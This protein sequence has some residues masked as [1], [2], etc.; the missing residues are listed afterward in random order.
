MLQKTYTEDFITGRRSKNVGQR[1]RYYI[2]NSHPEIIS[3]EVF[4]KVQEEM[5]KRA[6]LITSEDGTKEASGSKYNGNTF[7]GTCLCAVIAVH[8]IGEEPK[9]T[10]LFGDVRQGLRKAKKPALT[11]LLWMKVGYRIL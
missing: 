6:R 3:S 8:L 11:P 7:W 5:A 10:K 2:P 9:E 1:D 4:D